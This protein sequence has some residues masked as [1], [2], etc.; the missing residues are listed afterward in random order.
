MDQKTFS[1]P[2]PMEH[3][4]YTYDHAPTPQELRQTALEAMRDQLTVQWCVDRHYEYRKKGSVKGKLFWHD[5]QMVFSGLPY[6]NGD[7][8]LPQFMDFYNHETGMVILPGEPQEMNDLIGNSCAGSICCGW[9]T[10]CDSLYGYQST[11]VMTPKNGYLPV[12]P[13]KT[14][15]EVKTFSDHR[16]N[17]ICEENGETVMFESYACLQLADALTSNADD[18]AIMV[19]TAPTVVRKED[20][21]IDPEE[22]Y[23]E[24]QDQRGGKG[25]GFYEIQEGENTLYRS[26][27]TWAKYTFADLY[28][29]GYLPVTTKEFLG[30]K[31]WNPAWVSLDKPDA[32]RLEDVSVVSNYPICSL[33]LYG[34][35]QTGEARLIE[36]IG[37]NKYDIDSGLARMYPVSNLILPD[38]TGYTDLR[39]EVTVSTNQTFTVWRSKV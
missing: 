33:R 22:S 14:D 19:I 25:K 1:V 3:K 26:G 37:L 12:G 18:H 39:L 20:G 4:E 8:G 35:S 17:V 36:R 32:E 16:T 29:L 27:R 5:P 28:R 9:N 10:V 21:S 15:Y 7:G 11:M 6:S 24:I 2:Q 30:I 31:S 34:T 13:Y 23:V 38:L